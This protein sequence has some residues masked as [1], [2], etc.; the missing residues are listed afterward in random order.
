MTLELPV[1]PAVQ[2]V[3]P[4]NTFDQRVRDAHGTGLTGLVC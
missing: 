3:Q 1:L 2:P 4:F